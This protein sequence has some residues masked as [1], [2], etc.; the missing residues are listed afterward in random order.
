LHDEEKKNIENKHISYIRTVS[1]NREVEIEK[2]KE[3]MKKRIEDIS[4]SKQVREYV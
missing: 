3:E 4:K 1:A 2:L